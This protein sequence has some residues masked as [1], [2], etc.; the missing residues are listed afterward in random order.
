M[1]VDIDTLTG[2]TAFKLPGAAEERDRQLAKGYI[3]LKVARAKREVLE[4]YRAH[5]LSEARRMAEYLGAHIG[6]EADILKAKVVRSLWSL[7]T[8]LV[9]FLY[10]LR[11]AAVCMGKHI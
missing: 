6:R 1:R 4:V 8:G 9:V 7:E 10:R 11:H 3:R 2:G 5:G